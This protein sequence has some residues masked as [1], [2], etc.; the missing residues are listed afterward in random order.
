ML[1][2]GTVLGLGLIG[3]WPVISPAG[4]EPS[5]ERTGQH[6]AGSAT[7]G[8]VKQAE[9]ILRLWDAAR[10]QAWASG[11]TP[12]LSRL[13][14]PGSSAGAADKAML[15]LW[16]AEGLRVLEMGRTI[17]NLE[18]V[19]MAPGQLVVQFDETRHPV[20]VVGAGIEELVNPP[21]MTPGAAQSRT[22]ELRET[23]GTWRVVS[24]QDR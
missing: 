11:S 4:D 2:I 14:A 13:Y 23:E 5:G 21:E 6:D 20:V 9:Q 17:T 3:L 10:E 8:Q 22:V 18:I 24:V 15:K 1:L 7:A 16:K 12:S 19:T